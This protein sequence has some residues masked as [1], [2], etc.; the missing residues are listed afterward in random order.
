MMPGCA[1]NDDLSLVST[2][3]SGLEPTL[4]ILDFSQSS[5]L[6]TQTQMEKLACFAGQVFG[7]DLKQSFRC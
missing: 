1:V 6:T 5:H 3:T 7:S 2:V 4:I